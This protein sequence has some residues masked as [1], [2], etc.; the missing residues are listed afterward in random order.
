M[1]DEVYKRALLEERAMVTATPDNDRKTARLSDIDAELARVGYTRADA[2]SGVEHA[3]TEPSETAVPR[4][5]G[6]PRKDS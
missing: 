5:R 4:R 1:D 2:H 3:V 6:R